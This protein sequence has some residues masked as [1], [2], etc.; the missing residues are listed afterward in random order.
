MTHS[1]ITVRLFARSIGSTSAQVL[2]SLAQGNVRL[3][4]ALAEFARAYAERRM[5]A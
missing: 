5:A 1:K 2:D 3:A 4:I